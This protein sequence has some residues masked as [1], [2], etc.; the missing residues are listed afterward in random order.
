MS[1]NDYFHKY[2][3]EPLGIQNISI[4]PSRHMKDNLVRM[5]SRAPDGTLKSCPHV[6]RRAILAESADEISQIFNG[7]GGG[8]F[9][10]PAE[11]CRAYL[12]F[13]SPYLSCSPPI[14]TITLI[15]TK[16]TSTDILFRLD[17]VFNTQ[18]LLSTL[19]SSGIAPQPTSAD[20][21]TPTRI[22]SADSINELFTNQIPQFPDFGLQPLPTGRPEFTNSIPQ[23]Y[24]RPPAH[25]WGL[26]GFLTLDEGPTGRGAGT[27]H[28]SG[29]PN[30]HWW[31]DRER[32]VAGMVAAQI[33]PF[34]GKFLLVRWFLLCCLLS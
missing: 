11:Y 25:G 4:F 28:W 15:Q 1:L 33:I 31:C 9:A 3:F 20:A 16:S 32:G 26:A 13:P 27:A 18:G 24:P 8:L 5:H 19:L 22:L 23:L 21:P 7:A 12:S 29:L 14:P 30:L 17:P 10:V 2:I 34:G 6:A